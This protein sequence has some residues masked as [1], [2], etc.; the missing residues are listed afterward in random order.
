MLETPSISVKKSSYLP[1]LTMLPFQ[2]ERLIHKSF[3]ESTAPRASHHFQSHRIR[4]Q[5]VERPAPETMPLRFLLVI[6]YVT[7]QNR[8]P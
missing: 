1:D 4:K 2:L 5:F 3:P 6:P 7:D 8:W